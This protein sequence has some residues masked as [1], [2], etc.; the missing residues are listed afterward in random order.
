[1][2]QQDINKQIYTLHADVCKILA[3]P[4]RL[5]ILQ[6]LRHDELTVSEIVEK[7]GINK[8]NISQHLAVMRA[9]GIVCQRREGQYIYYSVANHKVIQAFDLMREVLFEHMKKH[10]YLINI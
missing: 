2:K 9:K 8:A 10:Q 4:K 1:M 5:E 3:N 7:M 6:T